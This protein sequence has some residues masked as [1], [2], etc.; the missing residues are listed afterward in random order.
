MKDFI[1]ENVVIIGSVLSIFDENIQVIQF[2]I[3][4]NIIDINNL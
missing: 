2:Y 3:V 4:Y 1:N